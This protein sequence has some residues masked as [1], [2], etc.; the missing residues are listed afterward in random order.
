MRMFV[1]AEMKLEMCV[2]AITVAGLFERCG[3]AKLAVAVEMYLR[4]CVCY[5]GGDLLRD[6]E[7]VE[8]LDQTDA[9]K[10]QVKGWITERERERE[11]EDNCSLERLKMVR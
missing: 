11:R 3:K 5:R 9:V 2:L 4:I 1:S 7:E 6:I 10:L 8:K